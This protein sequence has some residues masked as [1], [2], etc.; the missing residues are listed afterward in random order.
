VLDANKDGKLQMAEIQVHKIFD[1]NKD[2]IVS[3]D[4]ARFFLHMENEMDKNEFLTTGWMLLKPYFMMDPGLFQ[5]HSEE[6]AS[7][8]EEDILPEV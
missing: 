5:H 7:H 3:D 2:G 4:E 8:D 1:Q 6:A